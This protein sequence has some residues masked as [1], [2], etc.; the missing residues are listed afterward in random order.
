MIGSTILHYEILELLGKGAMGAVYKARDTRLDTFRALKFLHIELTN[1][2]V[3]SAH[4]VREARTQAKL[5]HPNIAA[6][7]ALEIVDDSTFLVMEN[8]DSTGK[9]GG[10]RNSAPT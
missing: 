10:F 9:N 2:E 6:L 4:F 3:A 7:L 1:R 8:Q 5:M